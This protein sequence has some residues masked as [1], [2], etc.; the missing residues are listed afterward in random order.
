MDC[1]AF[2]AAEGSAATEAGGDNK[3][4]PAV[5]I[6][7][8]V[9]II[10]LERMSGY[11]LQGGSSNRSLQFRCGAYQSFLDREVFHEEIF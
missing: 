10:R 7:K 8:K 3:R 2:V 6:K 11:F 9:L 1:S 5:V 4:S